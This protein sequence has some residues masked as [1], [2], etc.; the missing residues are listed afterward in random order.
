KALET[1]RRSGLSSVPRRRR[2]PSATPSVREPAQAS[3]QPGPV[4]A[5]PCPVRPFPVPARTGRWHSVGR[6]QSGSLQLAYLFKITADQLG[7]LFGVQLL[8]S[9]EHTSELQSRENLV[10]RLL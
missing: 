9:E 6:S 2:A 8:R 4:P 3:P 10:C 7:L 5:P 1:A